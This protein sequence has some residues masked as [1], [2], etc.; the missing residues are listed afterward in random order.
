MKNGQDTTMGGQR[1]STQQ[2][3]LARG[4][5]RPTPR[6]PVGQTAA[7]PAVLRVV[8]RPARPDDL[9]EATLIERRVWGRMGASLN[10]LQR[11]LFALPEAF[12][13]AELQ[14]PGQS[15]RLVGLTNGLLWTRDFPRTYLEYERALP[16]ASHNPRGDVLYL[17]SLGVDAGLR[18]HGIGLRLLQETIEVG[19]RRHLK[20]VRLIASSRSRPL[21]ERAG[22]TFV[23]PL[24]RLFRQHRDL[25]PQPVLMEL[26][27]T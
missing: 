12:L 24:P 14:R 19:R 3:N 16:S 13:L 6:R 15:P 26:L 18:G 2:D 23:R 17:A 10:E 25:M 5:P 11:R 1:S 9:E 4:I 7:R 27:F 20:Q 21:C 22:L 8:I